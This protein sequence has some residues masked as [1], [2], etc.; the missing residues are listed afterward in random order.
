[1][2]ATEQKHFFRNKNACEA[3]SQMFLIRTI[4]AGEMTCFKF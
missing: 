4:A 3:S 2:L 1:M